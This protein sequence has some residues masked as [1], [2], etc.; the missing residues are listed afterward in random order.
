ME[1]GRDFTPGKGPE[2]EIILSHRY[3]RERFSEDAGV[4]G[5]SVLLNGHPVVVIG[6]TAAGFTGSTVLA[7]DL[8][9]PMSLIP[10]LEPRSHLLTGRDNV[11]TT[12]IGRLK[13][14]V[15]LARA[16]TEMTTIAQRL[17]KTYPTTNRG[18]GI[19]LRHSSRLPG[20]I[21][22]M[23]NLFLGVLG[24]LRASRWSWP[25]RNRRPND[26]AERGAATGV[27]GAARDRGEAGGPGAADHRRTGGALRARRNRGRRARLWLLRTAQAAIPHLPVPLFLD[28]RMSPT[29]FG[30]AIGFAVLAGVLS[31]FGPAIQS[32]RFDLL[33]SLRQDDQTTRPG[34]PCGGFFSPSN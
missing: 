8:W 22:D 6:V 34:S 27:R 18:R 13:P 21:N 25:A 10:V 11:F 26:R 9:V 19:V 2:P 1:V 28:L 16:Q 30:F 15:T 29:A 3:W 20:E 14:G 12:A 32:S 5:Q 7:P 31:S 24:F 33:S 23:A 17:E 4:I